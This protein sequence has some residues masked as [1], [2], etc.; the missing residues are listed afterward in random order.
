MLPGIFSA[1][2]SSTVLRTAHPGVLKQIVGRVEQKRNPPFLAATSHG[3]LH[4][5]YAC[6]SA[7]GSPLG[8]GTGP[9]SCPRRLSNR[10]S[11][12][13]APNR[14]RTRPWGCGC[15]GPA[16][17]ISGVPLRRALARAAR[18]RQKR[19]TIK[20]LRFLDSAFRKQ[21]GSGGSATIYRIGGVPLA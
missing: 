2:I 21:D 3:G 17:R 20:L 18:A 15:R 13:I 19:I 1:L 8:V 14:A 6:C 5:P 9:F 4:P 11:R 16:A 7:L 10:A 12:R